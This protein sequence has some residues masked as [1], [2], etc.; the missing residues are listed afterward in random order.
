MGVWGGGQI[1]CALVEACPWRLLGAARFDYFMSVRKLYERA[2][3]DY[4]NMGIGDTSLNLYTYLATVTNRKKN[5]GG[6][7]VGV[8]LN[9]ISR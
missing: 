8:F 9:Y 1:G 7:T 5:P 4:L 6:I 3:R 2:D